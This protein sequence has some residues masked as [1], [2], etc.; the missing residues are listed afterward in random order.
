MQDMDRICSMIG[1]T[2]IVILAITMYKEQTMIGYQPHG[3]ACSMASHQTTTASAKASKTEDS[4]EIVGTSSGDLSSLDVSPLAEGDWMKPKKP[5]TEEV[6]TMKFLDTVLNVE[7]PEH[8]EQQMTQNSCN[9][10]KHTYDKIVSS[11]APIL[12]EPPQVSH[13]KRMGATGIIQA[14]SELVGGPIKEPI[15]TRLLD[16]NEPPAHYDA[17]KK[18]NNK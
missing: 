3:S 8:Y 10:Q 14:A 9:T 17:Y 5:S 2:L 15:V 6:A 11:F 18:Q 13:R 1:I 12:P 4:D 7:E 16:F